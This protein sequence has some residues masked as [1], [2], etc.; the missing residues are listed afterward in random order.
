MNDGDKSA[1]FVQIRQKFGTMEASIKYVYEI[2]CTK[3]H[4]LQVMEQFL[5]SVVTFTVIFRL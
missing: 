4:I 3:A 5:R 2:N 1:S